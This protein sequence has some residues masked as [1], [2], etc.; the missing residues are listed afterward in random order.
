MPVIKIKKLNPAAKLPVR[1]GGDVGWDLFALSAEPVA[2]RMQ[3]VSTGIAMEL[4]PGV[5]AKIENRSSMGKAGFDVHGGIIDNHYRGEIIVILT[6][7]GDGEC[8]SVPAGS[9]VAQLV[10]YRQADEGWALEASDSLSETE[11]GK[12][13]FGSTG[14]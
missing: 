3:K 4:P 12:N 9:K 11:R 6:Y 2:A 1:R 7:H 13:G 14:R 5:W 10:V 8:P